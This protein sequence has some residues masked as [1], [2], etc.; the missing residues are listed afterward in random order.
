[1]EYPDHLKVPVR[2]PVSGS[3]DL[4]DLL[5]DELLWDAANWDPDAEPPVPAMPGREP[6][7]TAERL[8]NGRVELVY[9]ALGRLARLG[10][11]PSMRWPRVWPTA[12]R[13]GPNPPGAS[14]PGDPWPP[15]CPS[16]GPAADRAV[17][18]QE[19]LKTPGVRL[20]C[21][22]GRAG[23]GKTRLALDIVTESQA[24]LAAAAVP[25]DRAVPLL[26]VR[27]RS[28]ESGAGRRR[29][30]M[31]A[32]DALM[33]LLLALGVAE[34]DIPDTLV[35]RRARYLAELKGRR[36]V[37]LVDD[38]VAENQVEP[39]R[40]A[41]AGVV[42]V[43]SRGGVEWSSVTGVV[44]VRVSPLDVRDT[45]TLVHGVFQ[46]CTVEP[47]DATATEPDDATT[48]ALH[49]WCRGTPLPVILI[50]RWLAVTDQSA[51]SLDAA[52]RDWDRAHGKL[53]VDGVLAGFQTVAA[54]L[55]LLGD[56]EQVI[57]RMFGM[58][59]L[60]EADLAAVCAAT[61]LSGDRATAALG[62]LTDMGLLAEA[63]S[64]AAWV[65]AP[66]IAEYAA[67]W[68]W[69]ATPHPEDTYRQLLD[70]LLGLYE[71][72]IQGLLDTYAVLAQADEDAS[73]EW[74]AAEVQVA[75]EVIATALDAAG[76]TGQ[77]SRAR[78]LAS[79]YL[80]ATAALAGRPSA[81][82]EVERFIGPVL[83]VAKAAVDDEL[84]ASALE[85][86]S[87]DDVHQGEATAALGEALPESGPHQQTG[88]TS[89]PGKSGLDEVDKAIQEGRTGPPEHVI[90]GARA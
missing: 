81:R 47:D 51:A 61:G 87:G 72:R 22:T 73:A 25:G 88:P 26:A 71:R 31:T 64:A 30:A 36:P 85:R 82:R 7:E 58:L 11:L 48:T 54:M 62:E 15:S 80:A 8:R 9:R 21:I 13:P 67:A 90:F 89:I 16:A 78:G 69:A 39:L 2:E 46:A 23:V 45:S 34:Q 55:G 10:T 56:D 14:R 20:I 77:L 24:R 50:S 44:N 52:R 29:L 3:A 40:P 4:G 37:I 28:V 19:A 17:G 75:R 79:A 84:A 1:M 86:F 35:E 5:A 60:P 74:M 66:A 6:A 65:M 43:T 18:V 63:D 59:R 41:E 68:A 76:V 38:A 32:Y 57:V 70:P 49:D 42:V 33:D 83:A 27:L 12:A 53:A